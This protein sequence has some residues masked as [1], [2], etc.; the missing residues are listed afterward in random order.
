ML[1]SSKGQPHLVDY[2]NEIRNRYLDLF[3][4]Y[5]TR[6]GKLAET[7][8]VNNKFFAPEKNKSM[9]EQFAG[10]VGF[11]CSVVVQMQTTTENLFQDLG[12]SKFIQVNDLGVRVI[13][14]EDDF[15]GLKPQEWE[16]WANNRAVYNPGKGQLAANVFGTDLSSVIE[17]TIAD[18][19]KAAATAGSNK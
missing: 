14:S 8:G 17:Q 11:F 10:M 12:Q 9:P 13:P 19:D 16:F 7:P 3:A 4:S 6:E 2:V 18:R 1:P 5:V 15:S